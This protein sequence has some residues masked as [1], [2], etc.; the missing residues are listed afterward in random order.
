MKPIY[1]RPLEITDTQTFLE[2]RTRNKHFYKPFEPLLPE[3]HFT[4]EAQLE[5]ITNSIRKREQ[6]LE[7]GFGIFLTESEQLIGRV[8]LTNVV[9]RAWQS[10]TIGYFI[11]QTTQGKGY[12]TEAVKR[13]VDFAFQE[14]N[15]HRVQA[16]IMP[17]NIAS[18]RVIQKAGFREEGY[19]KNYLKINGVWEDHYTYAITTEDTNLF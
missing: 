5:I 7:Y 11:D 2:L 4:Y 16:A 10:C 17:R 3:S 15:L 14:A 6:D 18:I 9:R 12:T 8:N 1:L 13:A 19:S